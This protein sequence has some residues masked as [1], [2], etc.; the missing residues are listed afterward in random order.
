MHNCTICGTPVTYGPRHVD[1]EK[2]IVALGQRL[3]NLDTLGVPA[4]EPNELHYHTAFV[5]SPETSYLNKIY[6]DG[7]RLVSITKRTGNDT[8][9]IVVWE[10]A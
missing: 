1:L 2:C 8:G 4:K 6:A 7:Y 10:K 9:Y 5:A 3:H